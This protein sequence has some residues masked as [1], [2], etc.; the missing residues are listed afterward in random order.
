MNQQDCLDENERFQV[1]KSD[2]LSMMSGI[3][4]V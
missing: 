3:S 4:S 1:E 2:D